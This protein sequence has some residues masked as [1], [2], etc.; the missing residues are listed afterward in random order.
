MRFSDQLSTGAGSSSKKMA[1]LKGRQIVENAD[2]F[3][4]GS[5]IVTLFL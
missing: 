2:G 4:A 5:D 1:T 3:A